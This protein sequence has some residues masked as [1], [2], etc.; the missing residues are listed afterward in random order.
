M[1]RNLELGGGQVVGRGK[2]W[3]LELPATASNSYVDAQI[4]DYAGTP[5]RIYRWQPGTK[6]TLQA[7]FSHPAGQL[8]GTAGFGFWNAPFGDPTVKMPAL[9]QLVWFFYGSSP[10]HLPFAPVGVGH[11]WFAG[12]MDAGR[13]Q[14]LALSVLVL[15]VVLL[16]RVPAFRQR[17]L[18]WIWQKLAVSYQPLPTDLA[19]W[20]NYHLSWQTNRCCFKIDGQLVHQTPHSPRGRLGFV[21]WID[22]QYMAFRETGRLNAGTLPLKQPQWLEIKDLEVTSER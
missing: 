10:N 8:V 3:R 13:W 20:H 16:N 2:I 22:N 6:L 15:P 9:P 7:R 21:A 11:G 5:R 19:L 14:A 12:T 1:W 18:P 4:D 17:I